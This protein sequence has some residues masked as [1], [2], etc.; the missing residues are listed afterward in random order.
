FA[1]SVADT[2][3]RWRGRARGISLP[4]RVGMGMGCSKVSAA[5][6][7]GLTALAGKGRATSGSPVSRTGQPRGFPSSSPAEEHHRKRVSPM[8]TVRLAYAGFAQIAAAL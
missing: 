7:R 5:S 2:V 1:A 4:D 8:V 6:Q 3:A